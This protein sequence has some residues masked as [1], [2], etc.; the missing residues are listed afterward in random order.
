MAL[1]ADEAEV[2]VLLPLR[3]TVLVV[4][5]LLPVAEVMPLA[6]AVAVAALLSIAV[7]E[8]VVLPVAV[9]SPSLTL[10][11]YVVL[12]PFPIANVKLG[13][14][15]R[16]L[17]VIDSAINV[18]LTPYDFTEPAEMIYENPNVETSVATWALDVSPPGWLR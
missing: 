5:L 9:A 14:I 15:A 1:A 8:A 4:K 11:V 12:E 3:L 13:D 10:P 17:P 18:K 2:P 6:V 7:A 16:T